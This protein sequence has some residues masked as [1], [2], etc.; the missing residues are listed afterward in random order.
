MK[1][2]IPEWMHRV[3]K[4]VIIGAAFTG[5]RALYSWLE[6]ERQDVVNGFSSEEES[7]SPEKPIGSQVKIAAIE[8]LEKETNSCNRYGLVEKGINEIYNVAHGGDDAVI[9]KAVEAIGNI[10]SRCN[11][12]GLAEL[13]MDRIRRLTE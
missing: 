4:L 8:R 3:G 2:F 5:L 1:I 10:A 11:R 13:A 6:N 12:Y 7:Y 9:E